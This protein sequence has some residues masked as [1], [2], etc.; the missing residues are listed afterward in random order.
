MGISNK[1]LQLKIYEYSVKNDVTKDTCVYGNAYSDVF[2][3]NKG[4]TC[5][6]L[7]SSLDS[8]KN[9]PFFAYQNA[10]NIKR[11]NPNDV[12]ISH[13]RLSPFEMPN[14]SIIATSSLEIS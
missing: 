5:F 1:N 10:R 7:Y 2:L 12:F 4:F 3:L 11:S 8:A 9:K 13:K 6:K 14:N